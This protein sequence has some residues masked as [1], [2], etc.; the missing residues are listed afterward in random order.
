MEKFSDLDELILF[1]HLKHIFT[2][3]AKRYWT[4]FEIKE[5]KRFSDSYTDFTTDKI[6]YSLCRYFS[7]Y[8][9]SCKVYL[10]KKS[11]GCIWIAMYLGNKKPQR[12]VYM[13][14]HAK[15]STVF[16]PSSMLN[17]KN[18]E[19]FQKVIRKTF[20]G[21]EIE[22]LSPIKGN[23]DFF[24][25]FNLKSIKKLKK[26]ESKEKCQTKLPAKK[27]SRLEKSDSSENDE[28]FED[29]PR[30]RKS[31][32]QNSENP[33]LPKIESLQYYVK[34]SA[35]C[36]EQR[37]NNFYSVCGI[38]FKGEHVLKGL[39]HL[40]DSGIA[41]GPLPEYLFKEPRCGKTDF[42]MTMS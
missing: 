18:S 27:K 41:D 31:V 28:V 42:V 16:V 14:A 25:K 32:L 5:A 8:D 3:R 6:S 30:K 7:K 37:N 40:V 10:E 24:Q 4:A 20:R 2:N 22:Q 23:A 11:D 36:E 35:F 33:E 29:L 38:K 12:P 1:L 17:K 26:L 39:K 13:V 34:S 19:I 21:L 9:I 15:S